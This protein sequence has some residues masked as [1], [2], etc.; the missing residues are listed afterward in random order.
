MG[1]NQ[2]SN[3]I[4]LN[5]HEGQIVCKAKENESGAISRINSRGNTVW[6]HRYDSISGYIVDISVREYEINGAAAKDWSISIKDNGEIYKLQ[7]PYSSGYSNGFLMAIKNVDFSKPVE[8]QPN[9]KEVDGKKKTTIFIRQNGE[10]L[11]WAFT[12][13]NPGALPQMTQVKF[14]GET[15]WDDTDRMAFLNAMIENEILPK[16]KAAQEPKTTG[17]N[18]VSLMGDSS[19]LPF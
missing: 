9:S 5:I 15:R 3:D 8:L 12:K 6:E 14:K 16:I 7:I 4:F 1:L 19:D 11:K 2:K 17:G 18:N 13:D 10:T